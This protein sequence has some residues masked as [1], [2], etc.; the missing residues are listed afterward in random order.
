MKKCKIACKKA[1]T[2][3]E[4][5][6]VVLII[7][8]LSAV[9]LS[10]YVLSIEQNRISEA[11]L[12]L[13]T[14]ILSQQRY[15]MSSGRYA[16]YWRVLDIAKRGQEQAQYANSSVYCTRD[17]VQPT[18]GNCTNSGYK[19]TLYGISSP[20]SGVVAQRVNSGK[21]SYKLAQ[22]YSDNEKKLLCVAGEEHRENDEKLCAVFRGTDEYDPS[23]EALVESIEQADYV[24]DNS[25]SL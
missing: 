25:Y 3:M 24:E 17:P 23:G 22:F 9:A 8:I 1:F 10:T 21:Y 13:G 12:W 18:D 6:V 4:M 20:D 7:A 16:R 2:I 14:V 11:E 19:V 15:R 5:V